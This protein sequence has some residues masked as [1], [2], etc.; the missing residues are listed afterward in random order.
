MNKTEYLNRLSNELGHIP[1][2]DVKDIMQ[3]IEEHF[4][5]GVSEGRSE[6]EIAESLG[7]PKELANEFKDGAKFNQIMKRRKKVDG[8]RDG[9]GRIFVVVF[10]IFV[11]VGM[12][13]VLLAAIIAALCILGVDLGIIGV[14]VAS[15]IM[16][17]ITEF[18]VPFIFLLLTLI[19]VAIFL[20]I[21][22][23]LGIKYYGKGLKA[24]IRWNR[25][26]WNYG[27]GE[28]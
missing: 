14:I 4:D 2:G 21:L 28:D 8:G 19:C 20:V 15:I 6:A 10:N 5:A 3:S 9:T 26:V 22:L 13:L 18:L 1:Y 25:H 7:D 11:G 24:Y 23:I 17:K 12:W 16:G 27:L